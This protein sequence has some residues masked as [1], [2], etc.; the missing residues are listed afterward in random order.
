MTS[1]LP[2]YYQEFIYKS[3]YARWL[4]D[5]NGNGGRRENWD[6]TIC[7][8]FDFF[9][10]HLK[11]NNNFILDKKIR[12]D[13]EHAILNLK[14]MPSMRALMTAGPALKKDNV[15]GYNCAYTAIN[16]VHCFDEIIYILTCGTGVGFSVE[17]QYIKK[18]PKIPD[19][20]YPSNIIIPVGD[21]KKGWSMAYRQL[22]TLLYSGSIPKWDV[23]KVRPK[24]ARLKTFGGRASGPQPLVDLF[25]FTINKFKGAVG[26]RLSSIEIHDIVCKIAD[27][28]VS[29]GVRRSALISLSNFSD[30]RMRNA[31]T[32][33]WYEKPL[34]KQRGLAN[35]SVAYTEKPDMG[36]YMKEWSSLY[37]SKSG[38]RGIFNRVAATNKVKENGR[39]KHT[40]E[41][42]K[43]IDE[44][45]VTKTKKYKF[46]CNPCSEIILRDGEF[47]N[48]SEVI[49]R[50]DDTLETLKEKV[51]L[52]T[53]LGTFQATLTDFKYI[54][55][56]WK[57]NCEDEALLGV[58]LTGI[59]DNK[60]T[61]GTV[62][63]IDSDDKK[64]TL[65]EFLTALKKVAIDTNEVWAKKIGINQS[66]AITCIKPSGT[67]S[68]LTD[69]SSGIHA[70]WSPYYIRTVRI[71]KED[72]VGQLMIDAGVPCEDD[73]MKPDRV[74]VFSFP[75]K[76]PEESICENNMT[77][78]EQMNFVHL[79]Q[80]YW[81]EH[82]VSITIHVKEHEWM[83]VGAWV[84]KHFDEMSGMAFFPVSDHIYKQAPYTSCTKEKYEE[85]LAKMPKEIN[86]K[87]LETYEREDK[88][89]G[90]HTL[91]CSGGTCELVDLVDE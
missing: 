23:S 29:G 25:E 14:V 21:S 30:D 39:R 11:N 1:K 36:R 4:P 44:E 90:S 38:E 86:W 54:N 9:D 56:I 48:L 81:C 64:Y 65:P 7:R 8:Y 2:T 3:R 52:A 5:K 51:K 53:I 42:K 59:M 62:E 82:K 72:P 74:Y 71:D 10:E 12:E 79:Y 47:C 87:D 17:R 35:N 6:E 66:A 43:I 91:A 77:A 61:N 26:R 76:S 15:A 55:K 89:V 67:V 69:T 34:Q 20:L 49:I 70:R 37:E 40:Y 22:M 33:A 83:E 57:K 28:V 58:S 45:I 60:Y 19:V 68:Q 85:L 46:G 24:G 73:V 84:Y 78:V 18:L 50:K 16:H 88:T 32:G 63:Y 80:T 31:K 13:L 75:I 41:V 27:V